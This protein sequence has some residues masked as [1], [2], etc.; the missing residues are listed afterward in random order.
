MGQSS[1]KYHEPTSPTTLAPNNAVA[2]ASTDPQPSSLSEVGA[3]TSDAPGSR[4][5]S[6]RKSILKFVKPSNIRNRFSSDPSIPS[7]TKR[8]WRKSRRW[9]K[10][11]LD[12]TPDPLESLPTPSTSTTS[13]TAG[14]SNPSSS[15]GEK[16]KQRDISSS[17]EEDDGSLEPIAANTGQAAQLSIPSASSHQLSISSSPVGDSPMID[18]QVISENVANDAPSSR[19]V[20][21]ASPMQAPSSTIYESERNEV[22]PTET[23]ALSSSQ[24]LPSSEP[25]ET[26]PE[27]R[28]FPPPG[29]LV[30]VQGIVHTT[31]VSRSSSQTSVANPQPDNSNSS[32]F[33]PPSTADLASESRARNRLSTLLRR[34]ASRPPSSGG[35][36]TLLEADSLSPPPSTS[37][38]LSE[39]VIQTRSATPALSEPIDPP[40]EEPSR[41]TSPPA[42]TTENNV[43]AISSSSIDVLGT[44]LSVA[45]AA[46]AA[47][48]LTGSSEPILSSGLATP[49]PP[50]PSSTEP[51]FTSPS[52][53]SLP[54]YHRAHTP[55]PTN[56]IPDISAAGRAERMRQAWGTIRERLGLRPSASPLPDVA[57]RNNLQQD[58]NGDIP[59]TRPNGDSTSYG[60]PTDTREIMLAEMARAFN[61]GLGLNGLGGLASPTSAAE[62]D[63]STRDE[64]TESSGENN[65]AA[66]PDVHSDS[67][68]ASEPGAAGITLPPEGSFERFLVDLQ[69]DLRAALTQ[70]EDDPTSVRE[71]P[72]PQQASESSETTNS[73][74]VAGQT[75]EID[76]AP[77]TQPGNLEM[78]E[79]ERLNP[80]EERVPQVSHAEDDSDSDMPSLQAVSDSES[81]FDEAG[82]YSCVTISRSNAV[83]AEYHSAEHGSI[84]AETQSGPTGEQARPTSRPNRIDASGRINW[85][86]LYRFPPIP[87]R[88]DTGGMR[89]PF[90]PTSTSNN[91]VFSAAS[92]EATLTPGRFAATATDSP[93]STP[94][95]PLYDSTPS[96]IPTPNT[97]GGVPPLLQIPLHSVVP[98]IVVGLQSV[99]QD[100]RSDLPP[101][102]DDGIDIFGQAPSDE[103]HLHNAPHERALDDDLEG[104]GGQQQDFASLGGARGHGRARGW[105]SRAANAIRN[106]RPGRRPAETNTGM[107]APLIAPGSRTFLIYVIGG[108]YPP[109]HSIVTG[110]PNILDSFEALLELADLLGQVKPPTVSKDDID[111]SGLEIIKAAELV[112]HEKDGKVSSNCLDRCLIC[113]D[114]YEP[115]DPIRVMSCRHAF[116][117]S[118]VDEWL[119]K[120]R[121]NCPACRST[122]VATDNRSPSSM[123][124]PAS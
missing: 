21:S 5:S 88:L 33:R 34:S 78:P 56:V 124:M 115:E 98:V 2:G 25:Q 72:T 53:A 107:P 57:A 30:V 14:P 122:G 52:S 83:A 114:D 106:L 6:V 8:S 59:L 96:S 11:P 118:C 77:A 48:L 116:H 38:V 111:N 91:P 76:V 46:T 20:D 87:S 29:T 92:S 51:I 73:V 65:S 12:A 23:Q 109:D 26:S 70:V 35:P 117:K 45:A 113:L 108:Y 19:V 64:T 85:W 93:A 69:I 49:N 67:Q 86:R 82:M 42:S 68:P 41:P 10:A 16:G 22:A 62:S 40:R 119:Q 81:E 71:Q 60:T 79:L 24:R 123:P 101:Q 15:L 120:G 50:P 97:A 121:N 104:W 18:A 102:G 100:W 1:S 44:L 89:P 95:P 32:A 27:P 105:H 90:P 13:L 103:I 55:I 4:R 112:Q 94:L 99:N 75:A 74:N 36:I 47:S 54:A 9:S 39:D 37:Q 31:D 58:D 84:D 7:D 17:L 43:P 66:A 3:R 28:Q 61:I 80:I 110:G 63:Q